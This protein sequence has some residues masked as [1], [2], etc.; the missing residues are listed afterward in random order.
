MTVSHI[1]VLVEE[2][3]MEAALRL[4]LPRILDGITFD[5][6]PH[7]GK[8]ALLARLSERLRGYSRWIPKDWRIL[9]VVDRD[10][11]DCRELKSELDA[12]AR[13]A[14]LIT[15]TAAS[16]GHFQVINRIAI[17]E[18]EAWFFG[19]W[20][21]VR[22]A[23]PRVKASIPDMSPY[24]FPDGIAGG[25]WEALERLLQDAGYFKTG[26]RKIE[27][28]RSIAGHMDPSRNRSPSFRALRDALAQMA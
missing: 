4:I 13:A 2:P 16:G 26:L 5:I 22:A 24:R 7:Q 20:S 23:Y 27:A 18:L 1:E 28:A 8:D 15:R 3:L 17:E 19:D 9:V 25:T 14:G 6:H 11:Q 12:V 10:A 21:A